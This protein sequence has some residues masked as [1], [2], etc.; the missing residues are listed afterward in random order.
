MTSVA[1][2]NDG[3]IITA[4]SHI[5]FKGVIYRYNTDG[6]TD[7]TFGKNGE[8]MTNYGGGYL[9]S[10][11]NVII[12]ND[13]KILVAGTSLTS[14]STSTPYVLGLARFNADGSVDTG[15]DSDGTVTTS[16]GIETGIGSFAGYF[17]TLFYNC[18]K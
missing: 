16:F 12:Q 2:Q 9:N 17:A 5:S 13:G 18:N 10:I 6:T 15:F 7:S 8:V 4:G 3:K 1:I 14:S 11:T